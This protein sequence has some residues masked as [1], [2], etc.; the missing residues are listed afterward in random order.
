MIFEQWT[1][2]FT[3]EKHNRNGLAIALAAPSVRR[4]RNPSGIFFFHVKYR[5]NSGKMSY[6]G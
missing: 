5:L 2:E 1:G 6:P 4:Q 3:N